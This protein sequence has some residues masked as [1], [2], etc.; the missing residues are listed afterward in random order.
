[1]LRGGK[2]KAATAITPGGAGGSAHALKITGTIEDAGSQH[3]AGICFFPGPRA[4]SPANLSAKSGISFWARGDGK[5]AYIMAFS[6][7]RGFIP[8]TITFVTGRE[9]KHFQFAWDEFDGHD[10]TATLGLF[11]GGGAEGGAFELEIDDV[12][13]M[14]AKAK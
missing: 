1:M 4:M 6:Q 14:P 5:P 10:G 13:L 7:S 9:W 12:R 11:W 2:C 8:A 3:W